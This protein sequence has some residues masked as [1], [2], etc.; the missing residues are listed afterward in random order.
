MKDIV[1]R[2]IEFILPELAIENSPQPVSIEISILLTNDSKIQILNRD[3]R[4]KDKPTNVLSFPDTDLNNDNLTDAAS[5]NEPLMLG[6][7]VFAEATIVREAKEQQKSLENHL[8]HLTV[9]GVLHLAGYD[10]I[11]DED[12]DHM[13]ALEIQILKKMN[14]DNPYKMAALSDIADLDKK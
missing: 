11:N 7:I 9:H 3:Y 6:D 4:S 5:F 12:A 1:G 10:H 14:I 13:E 2:T 8:A